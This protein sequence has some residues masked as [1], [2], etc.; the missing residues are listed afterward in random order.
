V[1]AG[2]S[3]WWAPGRV[4]L[5]GE[6]TD[7][8]GGFALP[9][10]IEQG[11]RASVAIGEP[12]TIVVSSA[13]R[14]EPV[15]A[16]LSGLDAAKTTWAGYAIGVVWALQQREVTIPGLSI[17]VDS[18]VPSGSGLAS[19]AALVCSV[20][21]AL[22]D[23]LGLELGPDALLAVARSAENDFVGAPTGGLDQLAAL[24]CAAG[25]ALF[26]DMRALETRQVPLD[27]DA[28]GLALLVIDTRTQHAHAT[29]EYGARRAACAE[30]ARQLGV[31]TLR[32]VDLPNLDPALARL[33][34]E[35][36]R[37]YVRHVV[38][39]NDRVLH[40]VAL[41]ENGQLATIGPLLTASHASLRDDY[42]VT[43]EA[44]D[45]AV[46]A[47]IAAGAYGARMTGGGF[48]GCV[49]ALLDA[50][51]AARCTAAVARAFRDRGF[52]EPQSFLARPV[53]GAHP[54]T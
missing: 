3:S 45:A 29:G 32:E 23:L 11:C 8:N 35:T 42:R 46:E 44:L 39:E 2:R 25:H 16:A 4:N 37:R 47:A 5:I 14:E 51:A 18:D 20:A 22:A 15:T 24:R 9:F 26:C 52:A 7:Y 19:S 34:D 6:H 1:T 50:T 43:T 38:T 27:P 28:A 36:L 48:G 21:S 17:E 49:I 31:H 12:G 54:L 53:S 33:T 13:Q 30:A 10:A 41:L 40:T